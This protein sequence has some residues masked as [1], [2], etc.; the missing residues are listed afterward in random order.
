V[1]AGKEKIMREEL[2]EDAIQIGIAYQKHAERQKGGSLPVLNGKD[3]EL[4]KAE[5]PHDQLPDLST[6]KI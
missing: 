2:V 6:E 5:I 1:I 4:K 3:G